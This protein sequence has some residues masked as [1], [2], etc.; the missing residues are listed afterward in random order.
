MMSS[1]RNLTQVIIR[2]L[3]VTSECYTADGTIDHRHHH[4]HHHHY[5]PPFPPPLSMATTEVYAIDR[6]SSA[7]M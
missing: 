5:H 1:Y 4:H 6:S 3:Y 2:L 7:P